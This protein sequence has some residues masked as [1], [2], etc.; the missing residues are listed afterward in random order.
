VIQAL[1]HIRSTA[2]ATL[3]TTLLLV[4]VSGWTAEPREAVPLEYAIPGSLSDEQ[5]KAYAA[6]VSRHVLSRVQWQG[7]RADHAVSCDVDIGLAPDGRVVRRQ[8][9]RQV[10][11]EGWCT[12]VVRGIDNA[13]PMP[14]DPNGRV[15]KELSISVRNR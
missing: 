14:K 15:P 4:G 10:G 7:E 13:G 11:S 8:V 9:V 5:A 2:S 12:A 3:A 1:M 6:L